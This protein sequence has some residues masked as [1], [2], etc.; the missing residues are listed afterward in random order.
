MKL[1]LAAFLL[2][3]LYS[4][5]SNKPE[6]T[7]PEPTINPSSPTTEP[8]EIAVDAQP[9]VD[10]NGGGGSTPIGPEYPVSRAKKIFTVKIEDT[11][12]NAVQKANLKKAEE[13]LAKVMNSEEFKDR[14]IN[15]VYNKKPPSYDSNNGLTNTQIYDKLFAGA[16]SLLPAVNYQ[17]DLKVTMYYKRGAVIGFTTPNSM[18]VNTN[19][20]FHNYFTA[21]DI[22]G[23]LSHEWTHKMGF[24]HLS[25]KSYNSVPYSIGYL[26][27][28]LCNKIK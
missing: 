27:E 22:A 4:C 28:E 6:P 26:V 5:N 16:E 11:N 25:A 8:T 19:S 21:C 10:H 1:I 23:N 17:M 2:F 13:M 24:D 14:V 15:N 3:N 18:I 20:K 9:S 7:K 12:Y